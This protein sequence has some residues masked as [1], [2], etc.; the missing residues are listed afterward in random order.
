M[1]NNNI[2]K[3]ENNGEKSINDEQE[4][5][6]NE[7]NQRVNLLEQKLLNKFTY[8]LDNSSIYYENIQISFQGDNTYLHTLVCGLNELKE[9]KDANKKVI[10]MLHGYQGNSLNFYKIIPYIYKDFICIC[11]DIIGMGVS[12]RVNMEFESNEQ[13][14][15]FFIESIEA[16][17]VALEKNYNLKKKF[18]LCGHSLGGYFAANYAL[19]YPNNIESLLLMSPTGITDVEQHGGSIFEN[20]N[21]SMALGMRASFP[22]WNSKSTVQDYS[23]VY[24]VKNIINYSLR[25]RYDVSKEEN[26]ILGEITEITLKYPK[27]LDTAIYFIFKYPFPTPVKPLE[28]K[29]KN[30]IP[31]MKIIFCYG[32]TDWM[33]SS[34]AKR[35][36]E[37]NKDKYKYFTIYNAGHTHPLDNPGENAKIILY[38]LNK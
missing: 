26:D 30:E 13:C 7:L 5:Q 25:K 34:G 27:D 17:R 16:F 11:P 1:G 33:D 23:Q 28:D 9:N 3:D 10:I 6:L 37:Y 21:N 36:N 15:N 35:L 29:I 2:K 38:E 18:I 8:P 24:I 22:L 4:K 32:E 20:M 12:S 31:D 19:K 14:V